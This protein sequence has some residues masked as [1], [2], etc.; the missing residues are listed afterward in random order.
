MVVGAHPADPFERAGGTIANHLGR[1]DQVM[2]V[3]L[4][5]GVATHAFGAFPATGEGKLRD[6]ERVKAEK[7]QESERAAKMLGLTDWRLYD[8]PESPLLYGRAEYVLLVGLIREFRPS[9][10]VCPHPVEVGRFDHMD[11][12]SL[13]LRTVDYARA[14]GFPS[15]LAPHAV[16]NIF[17]SYYQ[18]F[19]T[20]QLMGTARHAPDVIVDITEVIDLKR[21]AMLEFGTTQAKVGE[22]YP[23]RLGRFFERVDGA[24]GYR[25]GLGQGRGYG[26]QF[27]RWNPA[28]GK[29]LP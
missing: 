10:V 12:G 14:D 16:T 13:T 5:T 25:Y 23:E 9:V 26:E 21:R 18:D 3:S 29:Y 20:E 15:P 1:G 8:L 2:A 6:I 17:M 22:D 7:R 19:R 4:T 24:V 28:C 11:C 27:I